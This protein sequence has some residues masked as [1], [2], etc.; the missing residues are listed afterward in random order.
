M[1]TVSDCEKTLYNVTY[2]YTLLIK[3]VIA[4][5]P[6]LVKQ[7]NGSEKRHLYEITHLGTYVLFSD[8]FY[9]K[10]SYKIIRDCKI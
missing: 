10:I 3:H 9:K 4:N 8:N 2:N 6:S 1:Q 7:L 5:P